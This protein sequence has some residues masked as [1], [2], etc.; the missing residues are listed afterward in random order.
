LTQSIIHWYTHSCFFTC[1]FYKSSCGGPA[2]AARRAATACILYCVSSF[3]TRRQRKR[4]KLQS[5]TTS[6]SF[7]ATCPRNPCECPH[8]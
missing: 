7:D 1:T 2:V 3:R 5:S 8:I 6:L 4:W